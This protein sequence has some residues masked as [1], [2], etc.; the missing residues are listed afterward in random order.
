MTI[1]TTIEK[2]APK[3]RPTL[4]TM[5]EGKVFLSEYVGGGNR[6]LRVVVNDRVLVFD[7]VNGV[8]IESMHKAHDVAVIAPVTNINLTIGKEY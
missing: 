8:L 3:V 1:T 4:D 7:L 5:L 6:V 2:T